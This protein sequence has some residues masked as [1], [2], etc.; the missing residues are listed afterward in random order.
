MDTKILKRQLNQYL[1][2]TEEP[3]TDY[4]LLGHLLPPPV[5]AT[6]SR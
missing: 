2:Y 6:P 3:D 5:V 1:G 4:D